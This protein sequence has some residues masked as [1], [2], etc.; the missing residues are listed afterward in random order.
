[1]SVLKYLFPVPKVRFSV[2][3]IYMELTL[4]QMM[5]SLI[6]GVWLRL[7]IVVMSFHSGT[8]IWPITCHSW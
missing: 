1:M 6:R 7:R 5:C 3:P 2:L 8:N 4:P